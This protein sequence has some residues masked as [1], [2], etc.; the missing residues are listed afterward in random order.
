[1]YVPKKVILL[2]LGGLGVA[3]AAAAA[4]AAF[5]ASA[6]NPSNTFSHGTLVL[7]VKKGSGSTC[8]STG[9]GNTDTN[10]NSSCENVFNESV[11]KPGDSTVSETITV[12]N[13]GSIDASIFR[14]FSAACSNADN[15]ESY[16]GSGNPCSK[17]QLYLQEFSDSAATTPSTCRYGGGNATTCDFSDATKTIGDFATSYPDA[18]NGL[19]LGGLTAGASRYF[20]IGVMLPASSNNSYQGRKATWDVNWYVGQ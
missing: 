5:T 17:I 20:K 7:S 13:E 14:V 9:G 3:L 15:G 19:S 11:K 12:K 10:S 16:H 18:T 1:M 6:T 8:F 4:W 2:V